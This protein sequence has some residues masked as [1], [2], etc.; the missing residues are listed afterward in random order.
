MDILKLRNVGISA[1]IDS[2]KTT[3]TERIL[4]Y[5][6]KIY[7]I[8]EVR[9]KDGVGATMD[10]MELEK[11]RGITIASAATNVNWK[12][13]NLNIIDTPGHVDF[14]I[15]VE[16]ALRVLDGAVLVLC[17]VSGVQ[18][19][20]ITVDRQ[21]KRYKVPHIAFIN[22][23]DR[24]GADPE[25]VK[26]QLCE[27]LDH[28]AVLMQIP[29]GLED[30]FEGIIDLT[31][32]KARYFTGPKGEQVLEKEVPAEYKAKT[33]EMREKMIDAVSMFSD[34]LAEAF[35][36]GT[37]TEEMIISAVRKATIA[38][39][40]TP[41]FLG[42]AFKNKGVQLLLDAVV[43]YLPDP[44]TGINIAHDKDDEM[45]N[46]RLTS[47]P[48]KPTVA[49][50]FKLENQQYGQLT[51]IRIYQGTISKGS[52]LINAR[53]GNKMKV[54]R[55][56]KMHADNMEDIS[57]AKA[58]DIVA[59]FGIDCALGDTFNSPETNYT[60]RESFVPKPIISLALKTKDNEDLEKLSK[61]LTRFTKEDPTFKANVDDETNETI[62][63]G[64]GE[65]H[66]NV[67]IER[68]RREYGVKLEVLPPQVS[69]RET[70]TKAVDFDYIHKKQTGGRGQFAR[71]KGVLT[72]S[73][74]DENIFKDK[75]TG[76]N[77]PKE[78]IPG[79]EKGFNASLEEGELMGF[80]VVGVKMAIDDGDF[81]PVDSSQ[82]AFETATKAA[83][84]ENYFKAKPIILEPVMKVSVETPSE[85]RGNIMAII[86]QNRGLVLDTVIDHH[87][88]R[89]DSEM[90]LSETFGLATKFRSATQGKANFTMEFSEYKAVPKNIEEEL[91]K[92]E[93][94]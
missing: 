72:H 41:V 21:L 30:K 27:K 7:R 44:T 56:V 19:Q 32:R 90:P 88:T 62:V 22:K 80:P 83:F 9:G 37:E 39:E 91:L 26:D 51:Y 5:C 36:E 59:L 65:L 92:K 3:L 86:N 43:R 58:G 50:A 48:N 24:V 94:K 66:L 57:I 8:G 28:N 52:D 77:I 23:L 93:G 13:Y 78:Y 49:L 53:T 73:G 60:M 17:G 85:F 82:L 45:R 25:K 38:M 47:D 34:E 76:G 20:S 89:V 79:C 70:L 14:T 12:G 63:H 33:E 71:I 31:S 54:G 16:N 40:M 75:V 64:M 87:F 46:I 74:K 35:L 69:Y 11:E 10:S 2:G 4:Y 81:H 29:I 42:S 84:R 1:H 15:E 6:N 68:I 18:S 61:A 55:L 67:Y